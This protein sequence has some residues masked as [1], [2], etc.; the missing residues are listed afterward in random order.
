MLS[1]STATLD[2]GRKLS[3]Y[4]QEGVSHAW[5][6]DPRAHT[7]EVYR[8]GEGGWQLVARHGGEEVIRAE[9]FDAEPLELGR[10][11]A[12]RPTPAPGP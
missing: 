2:R 5:L 11:W 7:L 6:L 10:L 1:P 9:P 4:H 12:P 8:R 3:L